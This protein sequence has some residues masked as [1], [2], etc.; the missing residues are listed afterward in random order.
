MRLAAATVAAP[1]VPTRKPVGSGGDGGE[2]KMIPDAIIGAANNLMPSLGSRTA[3]SARLPNSLSVRVCVCVGGWVWVG[4]CM[5]DQE[6]KTIPT[7]TH[8]HSLSLHLYLSLSLSVS[9]SRALNILTRS[10][11]KRRLQTLLLG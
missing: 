6:R 9:L 11:P 5:K 10:P 7:S 1:A 8:N 4:V 2:K 3:M